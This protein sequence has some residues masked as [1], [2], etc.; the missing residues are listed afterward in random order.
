MG[1]RNGQYIWVLK[2]RHSG[3]EDD[4]FLFATKEQAEEKARDY[5]R[6]NTTYVED[7]DDKGIEEFGYFCVENEIGY[8][9]IQPHTNPLSYRV[10]V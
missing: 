6:Y 5:F 10:T 3:Y 1:N 8:F 7:F 9:D 2:I 4:V